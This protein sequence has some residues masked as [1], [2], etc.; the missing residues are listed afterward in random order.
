MPL[1]ASADYTDELQSVF[2]DDVVFDCG[3]WSA[4]HNVKDTSSHQHYYWFEKKCANWRVMHNPAT[5]GLPSDIHLRSAGGRADDVSWAYVYIHGFDKTVIDE[6][7]TVYTDDPTSMNYITGYCKYDGFSTQYWLTYEITESRSIT[8]DNGGCSVR[9]DITVR[10]KCKDDHKKDTTTL[11]EKIPCT[12]WQAIDSSINVSI[13]NFT[14]RCTVLSIETPPGITGIRIDATS[15]NTTAFYEKHAYYMELNETKA[16]FKFFD[17]KKHTFENRSNMSP[18]GVNLYSL[19]Q[20]DYNISVTLYTPFEII[21]ADITIVEG[22]L[23]ATDMPEPPIKQVLYLLVVL[24]G[25]VFL[26]R[27]I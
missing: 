3:D 27:S 6:A 22:D 11:I 20:D 4:I 8:V 5:F 19:P 18:I 25:F 15:K 21:D 24:S 1:T 26:G 14:D 12:K 10:C 16:G 7:G 23:Y 17:L 2:S 13:S 9:N